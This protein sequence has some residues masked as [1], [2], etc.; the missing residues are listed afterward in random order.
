MGQIADNRAQILAITIPS[1]LERTF[2]LLAKHSET[3]GQIA[4]NR[5]QTLAIIMRS[6]L[7]ANLKITTKKSETFGKKHTIGH[8]S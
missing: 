7:E 3:L 5:A 2:K 6:I 1:I 8:K 4:E